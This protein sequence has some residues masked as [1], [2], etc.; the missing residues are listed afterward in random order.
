MFNTF[1]FSWIQFNVAFCFCHQTAVPTVASLLQ[2]LPEIKQV[3]AG[4]S[5]CIALTGL[6]KTKSDELG[7]S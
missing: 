6:L 3:S 5:N 4:G 1:P 7:C 2:N